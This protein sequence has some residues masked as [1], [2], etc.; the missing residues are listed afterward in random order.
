[1][2]YP[3]IRSTIHRLA[4]AAL[5]AVA[6]TLAAGIQVSEAQVSTPRNPYCIR[7]GAMGSG[8][9]D[10]SYHNWKQCYES[11]L[12]AGGWCTENPN[13]QPRGKQRKQRSQQQRW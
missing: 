7:D 13:Y 5:G 2:Q 12:G 1:M 6:V 10:C 4:A 8:S 3:P 11:S 9:W